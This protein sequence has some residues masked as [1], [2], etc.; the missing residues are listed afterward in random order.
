[1]PRIHNKHPE[2]PGDETAELSRIERESAVEIA[3]EAAK[4]RNLTIDSRCHGL[5]RRYI[6]GDLSDAGIVAEIKRPYLN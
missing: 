3:L 2:P 5:F 4:Q 6:D 1:M